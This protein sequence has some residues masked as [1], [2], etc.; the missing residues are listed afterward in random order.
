MARPAIAVDP[1]D[2]QTCCLFALDVVHIAVA[3][4][5]NFITASS[6]PLSSR[7]LSTWHAGTLP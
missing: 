3:E 5:Q 4:V 7:R 6:R 2:S 1:R